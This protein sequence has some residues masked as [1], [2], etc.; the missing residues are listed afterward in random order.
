MVT[1]VLVASRLEYCNRVVLE[2]YPEAL[3][4]MKCSSV[5]TLK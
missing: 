5:G 3:T 2:E 1:H 4:G